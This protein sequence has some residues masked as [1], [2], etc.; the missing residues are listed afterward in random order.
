MRTTTV[1]T[2]TDFD[3]DTSVE[4]MPQNRFAAQVSGR[5]RVGAAANGGY[6][7]AILLRALGETVN[8]PARQIRSLTIH[9]LNPA[10]EGPAAVSCCI[11]RQGRSLTTVSARMEQAGR[12]V[13]L[14]LGAFTSALSSVIEHDQLP[15]PPL[16]VPEQLEPLPDD[17]SL[18]EFTHRF[19]YRFGHGPNLHSGSQAVETGGWLRLRETRPVDTLLVA[20]LADAW[21]PA[22][23]VATP[24]RVP[25]PTIDLTI[26]FRRGI[27]EAEFD[28]GF[29][30]VL[31]STRLVTEGFCEED[32]FLWDTRGRL[33]AQSRQL[34]LVQARPDPGK[35]AEAPKAD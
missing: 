13:C 19:E 30:Q 4:K 11:E 31:F 32:G 9:Y 22:V 18:P 35:N 26:H 23:F 2:N 25:V 29:V 12:T 5:W 15:A 20:A 34:A 6:L 24:E 27:D 1:G 28:G 8:D 17:R 21:I 10:V 33:V 14:A 16:A 7:S 3:Q